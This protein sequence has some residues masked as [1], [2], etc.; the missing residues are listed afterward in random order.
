MK[1]IFITIVIITTY[2]LFPVTLTYNILSIFLSNSKYTL[3]FTM[4]KITN[5]LEIKIAPKHY[6]QQIFQTHYTNSYGPQVSFMSH[7]S[8][9]TNLLATPADSRSK[10]CPQVSH[11]LL[12]K[13]DLESQ[14][15]FP[16]LPSIPALLGGV[17][18]PFP[19]LPVRVVSGL[20][21]LNCSAHP[22]IIPK[23]RT[24]IFL[25]HSS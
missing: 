13:R 25:G 9:L 24:S 18:V 3:V 8:A 15:Y 20:V 23:Q 4:Y 2:N 14:A 1:L 7:G 21:R 12:Q 22:R 10:S 19:L 5:S 6:L 16:Q 11:F 17:V